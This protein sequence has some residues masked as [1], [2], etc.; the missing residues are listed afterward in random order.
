M[1]SPAF[2]DKELSSII[3]ESEA[4]AKPAAK[5]PTWDDVSSAL[6]T[7]LKRND[8]GT[9][10]ADV[11]I[12]PTT[13]EGQR[14][15]GAYAE[16]MVPFHRASANRAAEVRASAGRETVRV[17]G[18]KREVAAHL[19]ERTERRNHVPRASIVVPEMPWKRKKRKK[20]EG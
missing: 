5:L 7:P 11:P 8:D 17:A 20:A 13:P 1:K 10:E 19:A 3:A 18:G 2:S 4:A 6:K 15:L 16:L 9:I 14:T 12:D